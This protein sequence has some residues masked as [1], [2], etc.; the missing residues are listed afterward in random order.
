M[1]ISLSGISVC[2]PN[3]REP[4]FRISKLEIPSGSRLLIQGPSGKGKTTLLHLIAGLFPPFEGTVQIGNRNLRYLTETE[5]CQLRRNHFG[6][7]FQK[8]NLIEHLTALENALLALPLK[9]KDKT[10][11]EEV[12]KG[13]G[14]ASRLHVRAGQ[15]SLGEQQRV[16]VG[17]VLVQQPDIVLADEPTSSLDD[18]NA[19]KVIEALF[20]LGTSKTL[21]VVSHDHRIESYFKDRLDFERWV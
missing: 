5:L 13:L 11:T 12:L 4:L 2:L 7:I 10:T 15:L 19:T 18:K 20:S 9:S 21:V 3:Q 1:T 8:L 16:A 6:L 14:L 17:R